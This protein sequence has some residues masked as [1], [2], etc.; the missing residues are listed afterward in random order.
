MLII[1]QSHIECTQV[2]WPGLAWQGLVYLGLVW[3]GLARLME[4]STR[5]CLARLVHLGLAW[6]G[7]AKGR[8]ETTRVCTVLKVTD[9]AFGQSFPFN[10]SPPNPKTLVAGVTLSGGRRPSCQV[11]RCLRL[12]IGTSGPCQRKPAQAGLLE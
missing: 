10:E 11:R 2:L 7:F 6:F 5:A 1:Y 9:L 8:E 12:A 4:K 3:F